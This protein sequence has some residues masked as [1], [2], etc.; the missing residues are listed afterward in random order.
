MHLN[1]LVVVGITLFALLL[2]GALL[3]AKL[4]QGTPSPDGDCAY[5]LRRAIVSPGE[6]SFAGVLEKI[7]PEG[8]SCLAKVRLGDVFVTR[9]GLSPSRRASAWNRINQK[10]VDFL[11]VR[12]ADF[13][14]LAGIELDDKSHDEDDRKQ[15]DGF[16]DQVFGGCQLPLLHIPAA[17]TYNVAELQAK[18]T[19]LLAHV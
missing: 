17:A 6:R 14:P 18:I 9:K 12:S 7:L 16:V 3:K 15:R 10:H 11:L 19:S 8:V 13:S 1:N 2:V 4:S 5:Q